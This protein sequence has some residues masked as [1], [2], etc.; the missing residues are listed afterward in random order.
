MYVAYS[1]NFSL[2][3]QTTTT[4]LDKR[5]PYRLKEEPPYCAQEEFSLSLFLERRIFDP[6][7]LLPVLREDRTVS[8][9]NLMLGVVSG[10][11]SDG[12]TDGRHSL[13]LEGTRHFFLELL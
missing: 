1:I 2:P 3:E 7:L 9:Q 11:S 13:C 12:G 10:N 5:A 4:V 6:L 8:V